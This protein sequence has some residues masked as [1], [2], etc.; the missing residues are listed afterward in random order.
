MSSPLIQNMIEQHGYPVL[1]Q[2]TLDDFAGAHEQV[3]LFFTENPVKFPES[4]D[5]AMIL[6]ELVKAFAGRLD[7]AVI[8]QADQRKLQMR[9]GF[10]EWPAL[11]FLRDGDYLGAICRV[12]DWN[13]YLT[14]IQHILASD[15]TRPPAF[16]IPVSGAAD[17]CC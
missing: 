16:N 6:P 2:Q 9:Y 10:S 4:N 5:V 8:D 11:V 3:V 13:T 14:Q 7:A 17:G 1:T 12:Q 15:V